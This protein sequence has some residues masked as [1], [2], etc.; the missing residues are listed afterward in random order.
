V[1]KPRVVSVIGTR[2]EAVKMAPVLMELAR[3]EDQC[4]SLLV[5]TAQHRQMLDQILSVF[6]LTPDIDLNTM[7]PNQ[8]LFDITQRTLD[9]MRKLLEEVTP[10]FVL[11]QG[12]TTPVGHVEAGLRSYDLEHPYPEEMNRRFTDIIATLHFAPTARS[13]ENLVREGVAAERVFVTGNP[14]VDALQIALPQLGDEPPPGISSDVFRHRRV[15][16]LTSHRRENHGAPLEQIC[17]AVR[18]I[19]E[20]HPDVHCVYPVHLNPQVQ[21]V[22]HRLLGGVERVHLI[23]PLDYWSFLRIMAK[24]Y[25]I[26]TDSGG[27]QEE[28]PSL[29]KPVLVLRTVT[30]RPEAAEAGLA[31]VI[32]TETQTIVDETTA[33]LTNQALYTRMSTGRNPYGDGQAAGRIVAVLLSYLSRKR[34]R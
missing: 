5:S 26:L 31:K 17:T 2:P 18:K 3:Y 10:D 24:S 15:I 25:V 11:V 23:P 21:H 1:K 19:V 34:L 27:V 9:G 8:T 30:E 20:R 16:L 29:G 7:L 33:L 6:R 28:A 12:D 14:V 22:V 13:R 32:G 4:E